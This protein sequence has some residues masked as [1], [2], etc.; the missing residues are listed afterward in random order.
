ME[1]KVELTTE[2]KKIR[3]LKIASATFTAIAGVCNLVKN[4]VTK[5]VAIAAG[6]GSILCT[7]AASCYSADNF[8]EP[9]MPALAR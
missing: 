6:L 2:E 5:G 8:G 3:N 7:F 9:G 4:P 1:D